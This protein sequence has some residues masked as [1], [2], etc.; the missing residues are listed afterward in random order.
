VD[1]IQVVFDMGEKFVNNKSLQPVWVCC[2]A[3]SYL[4]RSL[5][6]WSPTRTA[7]HGLERDLQ[8][9]APMNDGNS[10]DRFDWAPTGET[11]NMAPNQ[12]AETDSQEIWASREV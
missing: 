10:F 11:L 2:S 8:A 7:F 4:Y 6:F 9:A 12:E 1:E 3:T 5:H